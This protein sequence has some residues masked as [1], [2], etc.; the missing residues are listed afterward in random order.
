MCIRDRTRWTRCGVGL[1]GRGARCGS[2]SDGRVPAVWTV[3]GR[4][5][6]VD[7]ILPTSATVHLQLRNTCVPYYTRT[8]IVLFCVVFSSVY[9]SIT[10]IFYRLVARLSQMNSILLHLCTTFISF[11]SC[12]MLSIVICNILCGVLIS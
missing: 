9:C 12:F 7:V 5:V 4:A 6:E 11:T 3:V 1:R 2:A 10:M 8:I